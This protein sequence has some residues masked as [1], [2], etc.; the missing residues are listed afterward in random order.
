[1]GKGSDFMGTNIAAVEFLGMPGSGK[2]AL[3]RRV[4][5]LLSESGIPIDQTTYSLAHCF[6]RRRRVAH[7]AFFV[8]RDILCNPKYSILSSLLIPRT[9]QRSAIDLIKVLFNWLFVSSVMRHYSDFAG[10]AL[11]DEGNCQALWSIGFSAES[12]SKLLEME[13]L[14]ALMPMPGLL[15]IVEA[16]SRCIEAR[17]QARERH[18]SRIEKNPSGISEALGSAVFILDEVIT[19]L[20]PLWSKYNVRVIRVKNDCADDMEKNARRIASAVYEMCA[21][22]AVDY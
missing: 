7:K 6:G 13:N 5:E 18:D 14:A 20:E 17:L 10:I 22:P 11:V 8:L 3:S 16:D 4:G 2:S 9:G 21:M 19:V 1:M 15:V 12:E